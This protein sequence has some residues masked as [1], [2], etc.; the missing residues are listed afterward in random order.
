MN[1]NHI[2]KKALEYYNKAH[3]VLTGQEKDSLEIA[4]F[5][6]DRFEEFGLILLVYINTERVCAKEMVLLPNQICPEHRHPHLKTRAG[7]EETFR[8]RW[9]QVFLYVPGEKTIDAKGEIP[10][11]K[12]RFFNVH[13]QILL[14]PGEQYTLMPETLHWFQAGPN[15]VVISEFLTNSRDDLDIFTDGEIA[16]VG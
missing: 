6:L 1:K 14:N 4:D 3:I 16:R 5:G 9:G 11:D 13:H 2:I 10:K 8:C 15:G 12:A 7:K